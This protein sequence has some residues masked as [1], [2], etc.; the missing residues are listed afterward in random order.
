MITYAPSTRE[1]SLGRAYLPEIHAA[2]MVDQTRMWCEGAKTGLRF[3][4]DLLR[5]AQAHGVSIEDAIASLEASTA[6]PHESERYGHRYETAVIARRDESPD[7]DDNGAW[8]AWTI[9]A[10]G[11]HDT[12]GYLRAVALC[13][14]GRPS[15]DD[16]HEALDGASPFGSQGSVYRLA[17]QRWRTTR[18]P[19]AGGF[20]SGADMVEA[21]YAK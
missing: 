16:V 21:F 10:R 17:T 8:F 7:P 14:G 5:T 6:V 2:P 19:A 1:E 3:A 11:E 4:V 15:L 13:R 20:T 12:P 18:E 9:P